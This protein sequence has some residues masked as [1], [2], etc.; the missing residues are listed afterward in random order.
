MRRPVPFPP[1]T[2]YTPVPNPLFGPLL[3]SIEG[4]AE[5][6][7]T[8][9]LLWLLHQKK[10]YPRFVTLGEL[11]A[12]RVLLAGLRHC[13]EGAEPALRAGLHAAVQ[14]GTFLPLSISHD[15]HQEELYFLHTEAD[16]R[17]VEGIRQ[18]EIPVQG[19]PRW[20]P[21][22]EPPEPKPNIY[23]LY[24]ENIGMITPLVAEE[25]KEAEAIYPPEW[26]AEAFQEAVSR[27]KRS[28]RYIARILERWA[29]EGRGSHGEP[30]RHPETLAPKDYL[31]WYGQRRGG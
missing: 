10:G 6:K 27:N 28:W 19:L 22:A 8:L 30:G 25:L 24:E 20:E 21:T 13:P 31:R 14:R 16:Q 1:G 12:D 9:R 4:L 7:C 5:L 2:R 15:G 17:A 3:E 18:G 26:V 29:T 23:A 11:L